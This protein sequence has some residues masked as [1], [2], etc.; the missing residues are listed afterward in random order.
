MDFWIKAAQLI[1]SLSIL[2]ILHE[3]GHF[4]PA[5]IF[6]TRVEKFYL[7]FDWKFSLIKKKIGDTT[8]GIGWI[9]LGGYVKI[10]GMIDESM[11]KDQM[12][13]PPQPWEFRSKPAWQRLIIMVGGVVVN[14]I[15]GVTIY[16]LVFFAY[17]EDQ[18]KSSDL[19]DGLTVHPYMAKYGIHNGDN[20][21][22]LDGEKVVN[23]TA[24]NSGLLLRGNRNLKVQHADGSIETVKLPED[25]DYTLFREGAFPT[26]GLR[27]K[28]VVVN[29]LSSVHEVELIGIK[30]QDVI[31]S[32]DGKKAGQ[33]NMDSLRKKEEYM[34]K[35]QRGKETIEL[36]VRGNETSSLLKAVPSLK[37]GLAEGDR[38]IRIEDQGI[39]YFDEIVSALYANKGK[40]V[41]AQVLRGTD[42]LDLNVKVSQLGSIGFAPKAEKPIDFEA[43]KKVHYTF[44]QSI[45]RGAAKGY[46]TLSDYASQMKFLFTKKGA[47]SMGGFGALGS[48]FPA[49]WDWQIFWMNTALISIIL[50]FMNILPIPALDGG[51]VVFLLYEMITGKE[52]PQKVLEYA[53]Y[54]GF[55]L[56]LAL[57][58]FANFND[59]FRWITGG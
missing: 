48:L 8:W 6:K 5:R 16:I 40:R 55:F 49:T 54:I 31:L 18:I 17:G 34:V 26:V 25:I 47:S 44:G 10:A 58:I 2:I 27:H 24:V 13:Q 43:I 29:H 51:H 42:T 46:Q 14:I 3:L 20:I 59:I 11:D 15:V 37:G 36:P 38:I 56:I 35:V 4:I 28:S 52:A 22:E 50:A 41:T 9:P 32:I 33:N 21:L 12:A 1:L 7:F 39:T 23:Y 19:K 53:Q 45:S 30:K 57:V